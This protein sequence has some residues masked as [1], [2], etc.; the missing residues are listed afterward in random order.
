MFQGAIPLISSAMLFL[1]L[2]LA[3]PQASSD[4][5]MRYGSPAV[6]RYAIR[7][8]VVMTVFYSE[9]GRTCKADVE[10]AKPQ[11][12]LSFDEVLNEIIPMGD[13]GKQIRA[14]GLT[15]GLTGIA[16]ADYERVRIS[17]VSAGRGATNMAPGNVVSATIVW[18][19]VKCKLPEQKQ[20]E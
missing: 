20:R 6:E 2:P 4:W 1:C 9:E 10:P 19:G 15:T 14:L 18:E 17:V 3:V 12:S 8:G 13:R 11:T 5:T 16:Y 7:D